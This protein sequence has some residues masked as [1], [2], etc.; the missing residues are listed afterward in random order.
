MELEGVQT[1]TRG[2][3]AKAPI[4][5][6]VRA[7]GKEEVERLAGTERGKKPSRITRITMRHHKVAQLLA[8]GRSNEEVAI[9]TGLVPSTISILKG[10]PTFRELMRHYEL[11]QLDA[12]EGFQERMVALSIDALEEL[13]RRI[14][15]EPEQFEADELNSIIK[16][17]ADRTGHA[18]RRVEEKNVT[19]RFGDRLEQ[20]RQRVIEHEMKDVTP[21]EAAE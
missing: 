16:M 10:D 9:V 4:V 18:P 7:L 1:R 13:R 17:A 21:E 2:R 6:E 11:E 15:E 5:L 20:A 14:E 8:A 3:L 12:Y 19:F